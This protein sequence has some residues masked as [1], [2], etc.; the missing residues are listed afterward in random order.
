[1]ILYTSGTTG[2]PKGVMLSFDNLIVSVHNGNLFD[3]IGRDSGVGMSDM[4]RSV[5]VVNRRR[6][7]VFAHLGF[8]K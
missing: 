4:R 6:E 8:L 3:R 7:I 1:M 2:R 5:D